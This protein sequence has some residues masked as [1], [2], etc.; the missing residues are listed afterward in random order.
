MGREIRKVPPNWE[1]PKRAD[2]TY[3]PMLDAVYK[4][5]VIAREKEYQQWQEGTHPNYQEN[6][7]RLND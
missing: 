3:Y 6:W 2:G 1:H 7:E 4:E 5:A